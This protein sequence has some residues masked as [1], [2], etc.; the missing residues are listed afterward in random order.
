MPLT[1]LREHSESCL[2]GRELTA[3]RR[4]REQARKALSDWGLEEH[5]DAV[6]HIIGELVANAILHGTGAVRTCISHDRSHLHFEV[7]DDGPGR[8][9]ERH[10][11]AEDVTGRGL[12][13]VKTLLE[14]S[15]GNLGV[16][17]DDTG[18][19]KTVYFSIPLAGSQ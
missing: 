2:F 9:A 4:A 5:A 6:E 3:P 19:G 8:P 16:T 11:G 10:A 14:S 13:M 18:D 7:H 17:D 12:A 1:A 15:G